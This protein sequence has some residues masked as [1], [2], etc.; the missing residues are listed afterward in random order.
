MISDRLK[1]TILN[2]LDLEDYDIQD[3]T[4]ANT[5]PGW[6]S[7]SHANVILSIEKEY[8]VRFKSIEILKCKNIGDLQKLIDSKTK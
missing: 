2:H 4:K 7:L 5:V 6:D 1:T 3:E 8:G